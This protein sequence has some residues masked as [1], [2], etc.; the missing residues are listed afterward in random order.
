L[1]SWEA[2]IGTEV[3][4]VLQFLKQL[5]VIFL[6]LSGKCG[7]VLKKGF[8][9]VLRLRWEDF[10]VHVY[11]VKTLVEICWLFGR[12][13]LESFGKLQMYQE[14]QNIAHQVYLNDQIIFGN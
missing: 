11:W 7:T 1:A 6:G 3:M 2:K 10:E 13:R 4:G 8:G 5:L 9:R 14:T 12:N